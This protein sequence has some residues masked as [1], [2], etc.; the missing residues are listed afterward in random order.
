MRRFLVVEIYSLVFDDKPYIE[1]EY[2]RD[3]ETLNEA[4]K[5]I[6]AQEEPEIYE[7]QDQDDA[8]VAEEDDLI[9]DDYRDNDDDDYVLDSDEDDDTIW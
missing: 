3:F 8:F 5:W 7:I 9:D 6:D 2:V 1:R 4:E